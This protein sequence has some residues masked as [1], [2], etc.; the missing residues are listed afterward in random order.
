MTRLRIAVGIQLRLWFGNVLFVSDFFKRI[1]I[2]D[3]RKE[4]LQSEYK[5]NQ[6]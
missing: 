6:N 4:N 3:T 5:G 1:T 2:A